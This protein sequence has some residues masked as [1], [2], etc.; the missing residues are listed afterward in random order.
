MFNLLTIEEKKLLRKEYR[1]RKISVFAW[2]MFLVAVGAIAMLAPSY[3]VSK[4]RLF[5]VKQE[6]DIVTASIQGDAKSIEQSVEQS[7]KISQRISTVSTVAPSVW[8]EQ[9]NSV[10]PGGVSV[11][12]FN[13]TS[14]ANNT[15]NVEIQGMAKTRNGLLAFERA[16]KNVAH[17]SNVTVPI[18]LY[19]KESNIPFTV[20]FSVTP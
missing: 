19:T 6:A 1:Q 13:F 15:F 2:V 18:A 7:E 20:S 17:F 9:I 16:L 14:A 10:R 3:I 12:M 4:Y 11:E 8:L 5:M